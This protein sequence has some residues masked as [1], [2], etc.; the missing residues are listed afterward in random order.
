[1]RRCLE[2]I[3]GGLNSFCSRTSF[4]GKSIAHLKRD[5]SWLKSSYLDPHH[6]VVE[7]ESEVAV[8]Y[9][10]KDFLNQSLPTVDRFLAGKLVIISKI[11]Q[12]LTKPEDAVLHCLQWLQKLH[13]VYS[14]LV[15]ERKT[16]FLMR[17]ESCDITECIL[18]INK[19]LFQ[20]VRMFL[21][22]PPTIEEWPATIQLGEHIYNPLIDGQL[23]KEKLI[24]GG[25]VVSSRVKLDVGRTGSK[26]EDPVTA[27][28]E[29]YDA[30]I[31]EALG[32][33]YIFVVSIFFKTF[34]LVP[35]YL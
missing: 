24:G 29:E 26:E 9:A 7:S 11:L 18:T 16:L 25:K 22:P 23:L 12:N 14:L 15:Q 5:V 6:D 17:N 35:I 13:G 2:E 34:A 10:S 3:S 21:K 30:R 33:R 31:I 32:D 20:F 1:M 28:V 4:H 19:L 27:D 8:S